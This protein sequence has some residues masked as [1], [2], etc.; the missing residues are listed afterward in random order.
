MPV[1]STRQSGR[2]RPQDRAADEAG[3]ASGEGT[4]S[5]F[6]VDAMLGSLARKLRA[7]GFDA[8]YY[9]SGIDAELME[10][11]VR[12]SRVILTADRALATR[13]ESRGISVV[14]VK[15]DS[16]MERVRA[17]SV[18]AMARGI[19]L[20]RG[21]PMCS[22]CGGELTRVKKR[23]VSGQIPPAVERHHRLFFKCGSCG[24]LY[25]RGSHWKRLMSLAGRLDQR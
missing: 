1:S 15:G 6:I 22:L 21:A 23:E 24:Q 4:R 2:P 7:L 17:I 13:A 20:V 14:L 19:E 5:R 25:W 18:A 9:R 10:R 16:D 3:P 11:S 8:A 12:E